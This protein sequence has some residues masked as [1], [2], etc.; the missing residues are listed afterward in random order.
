M[1]KLTIPQGATL[2]RVGDIAVVT[3]PGRSLDASNSRQFKEFA[4]TEMIG[5]KK[6]VIDLSQLRFVDSS[7]LGVLLSCFRQVKS[8]GGALGLCGM[9][10]PVRSLFELVRMHRVF[11]IYETKEQAIQAL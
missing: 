1:D 10:K 4:A 7:G 8:S 6:V 5:E 2:E 3:I 11:D 9:S